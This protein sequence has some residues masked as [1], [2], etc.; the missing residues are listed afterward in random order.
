MR[1]VT[2]IWAGSTDT[3]S[4]EAP[5]D[6]ILF[7]W[8]AYQDGV[9]SFDPDLTWTEFATRAEGVY[10]KVELF[11]NGLYT[12][13]SPSVVDF[14]TGLSFQLLKGQKIYI[15]SGQ[16]A[17]TFIQLFFKTADEVLVL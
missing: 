5:E 9:I 1:C 17:R 12:L 14:F 13:G 4:Y 15:A 8:R 2:F 10:D 7:G 11:L 16:T 6:M 3:L